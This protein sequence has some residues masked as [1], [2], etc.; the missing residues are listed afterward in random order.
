MNAAVPGL[1]QAYNILFTAVLIILAVML[2][3][4]LVR[5]IM[6]GRIADRLL[7]VNM[8]GTIIMVIIA[9]LAVKMNEGYLMDICIIYAMISFLA[10]VILS[11]VYMGIYAE[12]KANKKEEEK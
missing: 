4:C 2:M 12:K 1:E 3:F 11:K 9:V 7:A 10:V 6:K 8:I 5:S